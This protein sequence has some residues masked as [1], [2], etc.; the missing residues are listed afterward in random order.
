MARVQF[1]RHIAAPPETVWE[2]LADHRGMPGWTAVQAVELE[3]EGEPAPNGVGAVRRLKVAPLA[4]VLREQ[5]TRFDTGRRMDYTMLSGAPVR[6][7]EAK[8]IL[9]PAGGDTHVD[10]SVTFQPRVPGVQLVV[11]QVISMLVKGL[12]KSAEQRSGGARR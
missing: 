4:P 8:V 7:Y 10:W 5:V 11:K 3:R 2:I 1:T 9:T 12:A 6:D